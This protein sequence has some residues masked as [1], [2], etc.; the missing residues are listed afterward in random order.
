MVS[1]PN[2]QS[3]STDGTAEQVGAFLQ[4]HQEIE[5]LAPMIVGMIAVNRFK[6]KGATALLVNLIAVTMTR[7]VL[8]FLKE[9][10]LHHNVHNNG[11]SHVDVAASEVVD[12][13]SQGY[14]IVHSIPGRIRLKVSRLRIDEEYANRLEGLLNAEDVVISTTI[15]RNAASLTIKYEVGTMAEWELGLRLM[16]IMSLAAGKEM[17]NEGSD[18]NDDN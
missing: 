6:A 11:R 7:K 10:V 18:R 5:V 17:K 14:R 2:H 15:N 13:S 16:N 3:F 12:N 4:S 8:E 9:P 1:T